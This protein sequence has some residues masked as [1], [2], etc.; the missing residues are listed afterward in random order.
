[1]LRVIKEDGSPTRFFV[2]SNC[3]QCGN[4]Q[5]GKL[6]N[7]YLKQGLHAGMKCPKCKTGMMDHRFH[8]VDLAFYNN[9]GKCSCEYFM[10]DREP[11]V[12]R[13]TPVEQSMGKWRCQHIDAARDFALDVALRAHERENQKKGGNENLCRN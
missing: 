4:P 7:K 13:E 12:S 10:Y 8:L 1:M 2:E 11:K 9:H 3:L 6:F 5:C